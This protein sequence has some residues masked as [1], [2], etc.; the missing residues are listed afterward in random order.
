VPGLGMALY[1]GE[2]AKAY[3]S[4]NN[5]HCNLLLTI[6]CVPQMMVDEPASLGGRHLGLLALEET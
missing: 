5:L 3:G 6:S 4:E 1:E 2:N